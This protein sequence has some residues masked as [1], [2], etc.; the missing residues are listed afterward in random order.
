MNLKLSESES[1][2][3]ELTSRNDEIKTKEASL[4]VSLHK[5]VKLKKKQKSI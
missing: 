2:I 1:V 3:C 4:S 5:L